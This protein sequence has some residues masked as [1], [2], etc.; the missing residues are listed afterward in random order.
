MIRIARFTH[1]YEGGPEPCC[2]GIV[3]T[4]RRPGYDEKQTPVLVVDQHVAWYPVG[5]GGH[6]VESVA[7]MRHCPIS[8]DALPQTLEAAAAFANY[9][10]LT[11]TKGDA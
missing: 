5:E 7:P 3:R 6:A 4:V 2:I 8:G 10:L 11:V 1:H 9:P